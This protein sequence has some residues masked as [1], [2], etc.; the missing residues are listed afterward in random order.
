MKPLRLFVLAFI[1]MGLTPAPA[2]AEGVAVY[3]LFTTQGCVTCP[4]GDKVFKIIASEND[5]KIIAFSCHV[6]Y[7]DA[8]DWKDTLSKKFCDER[9]KQYFLNLDLGSMFTPQVII[10]G[11]YDAKGHDENMIRAGLKMVQAEN[12][13]PVS[14]SLRDGYLDITLPK[15]RLNKK[16]DIWLIGYKKH[17]TT[18][19]AGGQ[20]KGSVVDYMNIVTDMRKLMRWNGTYMNMAFPTAEMQGDGYV[21]LAQYAGDMKILAAGKVEK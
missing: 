8:E 13:V 2:G 11:I 12:A 3:E 9:Q 14:L 15:M 16:A 7:F 1:L 18:I 20:N 19:I 6:S 10:G 17:E 21:V 5:P 4:P